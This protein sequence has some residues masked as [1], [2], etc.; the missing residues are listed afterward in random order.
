MHQLKHYITHFFKAKRKGH[1]VHSPFVYRLCEDVF[2]NKARFYDF[3]NLGKMRLFLLN[4][5]KELEVEDFGAGSKTFK[6]NTRKVSD[7]AGKGISTQ[8]QSELFYR[9]V[10][11]LKP[12]TI[13]EL[14]TSVGL[15]ALYLAK[16][17]TLAQVYTIEGSK[18]LSEY[19]KQLSQRAAVTN[20]NYIIA[21][22]DE[23][24]PKLLNDLNSI[25]FVYIDGNH[26]YEATMRYFNLLLE[27]KNETS[28]FIFDDIYWSEGMTKAW[29]EI[30]QNKDVTLSIDAF[31]F[32][33]VFFRPEMKER[34]ELRLMV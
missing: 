11:Y 10:N 19:A 20:V 4:E 28:V 26:T 25:D 7:I 33:M 30:K 32:G 18:N 9:L 16:A 15:N 22:F 14:G 1:D 24:V 2:Y 13:I 12:E 17:N 31:Y 34:V 21:K 8:K 5:T 27:K 29:K 6:G 3:E 23:Y